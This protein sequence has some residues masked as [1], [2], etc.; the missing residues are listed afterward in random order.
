MCS[1]KDLHLNAVDD[2]SFTLNSVGT[3]PFNVCPRRS[4][5]QAFPT[6]LG[7][8]LVS[9]VTGIATLIYLHSSSN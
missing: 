4:I 8:P 2:V 5:H 7:V 6:M 1:T 9:L 3:Y